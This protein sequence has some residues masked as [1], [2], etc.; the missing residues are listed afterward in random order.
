MQKGGKEKPIENANT[1]GTGDVFEFEIPAD[2]K[3]YINSFK[4][5]QR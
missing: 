1:N 4:K 5:N 3:S 2:L